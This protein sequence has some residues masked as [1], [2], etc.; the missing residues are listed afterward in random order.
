MREHHIFRVS[1]LLQILIGSLLLSQSCLA[2]RCGTQLVTEGNLALQVRDKCG[3]PVS[4]EFIGYT[5]RPNR[6]ANPDGATY[7]R[8]FK[9]E[10]WIYGPEMGYYNVLTFEGGRLTRIEHIKQ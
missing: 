2:L 3:D 9:I 5:L 8:E 10:Q 4:E 1:R 7:Q 6:A